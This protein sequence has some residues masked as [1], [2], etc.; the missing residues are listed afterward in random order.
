VLDTQLAEKLQSLKRE[1]QTDKLNPPTLSLFIR[2]AARHW[3][4]AGAPMDV[5]ILER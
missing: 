4:A 5:A 2:I 3:L 1:K